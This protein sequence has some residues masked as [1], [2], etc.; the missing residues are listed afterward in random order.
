MNRYR[1][2]LESATEWI[3]QNRTVVITG[4]VVVI[5]F[6]VSISI[7]HYE[8]TPTLQ[9]PVLTVTSVDEDNEVKDATSQDGRSTLIVHVIGAVC[10]PGVYTLSEEARVIDAIMIAGGLD[11][12]A[13]SDHVN[14]AQPLTDGV[15]VR[16]PFFSDLSEDDETGVFG[17]VGVE[18]LGSL[19]QNNTSAAS[20]LI[21]I[22]T[23]DETLLQTLPGIGPSTS[24]KIVAERTS[25]GAFRSL[26][27]LARV[28]GIGE[29]KIAALE[30]LAEAR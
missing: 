17:V 30:G 8:R 25:N 18:Q 7:L 4:I 6:A 16:I 23:A 5:C 29:K 26:S 22:N 10:N 11:P 3:D 13:A 27:D 24:S 21:D 20:R 15:Q 28:S 12:G 1:I 9:D 2:I 14:M 19:P